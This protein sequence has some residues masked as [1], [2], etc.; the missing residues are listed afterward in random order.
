MINEERLVDLFLNLC[1]INA[2]ALQERDVIEWTKT[3][4]TEHGLE[5][6]EDEAGKAIGGN[7]N[8]IIV[9]VP[10][11][12]PDAPNIY[13][14]AHFD[15]VEPTAGIVIEEIDGVFLTTSDTILGADDKGGMAPAIEAV[16][17]LKES[18]EPH[19]DIYLLLTVAEEIGL[20]GAGALKIEDLNLDFGYVLD[21][22][23]PVG[24]Y[25]TRTANHDKLDVTVKGKPA[26]AGKDPENGINA[27]KV[28]ADAIEGMRIG[29]I[30]PE[31]TANL[32]TIQGG[33][34]ANVVCAE[35]TIKAEARSTNLQTLDD[36]IAH[37]KQRFV[38]AAAKWGAE[39]EFNYVRHYSAYNI[40]PESMVVQLAQEASRNL[41]LDPELRTT[42]GGSDA[43]IFNAKGVPSIV[44]ATGMQKIH[45]HDEFISRADLVKTAEL[46]LEILRVSAKASRKAG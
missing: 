6:V 16:L 45:T 28:V 35:V 27:I 19:G 24:S 18:G 30:D 37:M 43:N 46:S 38:D 7:A 36:Q 2:P 39:V 20:Q 26:H 32:G 4:L 1:K 41:G 17:T 34:G 13:L 10:G 8:N 9:K 3:Y 44:V 15:T 29:R 14:S 5:F 33:T 11:N 31:T 40:D 12:L 25:V 42:L 22:G 21:T 23:P